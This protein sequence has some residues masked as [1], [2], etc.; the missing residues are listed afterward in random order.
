MTDRSLDK[1]LSRSA[2]AAAVRDFLGYADA[3][4]P[5]PSKP[6]EFLQHL[7]MDGVRGIYCSQLLKSGILSGDHRDV[8]KE[9]ILRELIWK[10][11]LGEL[12]LALSKI[13][14]SAIVLKG[15]S[16]I[17][18]LYQGA[19]LRPLSDIDL[20]VR[21]EDLPVVME[22]LLERGFLRTS[23][24]FWNFTR[25]GWNVD[26]HDSPLNQYESAFPLPVGQFWADSLPLHPGAMTLR[27]LSI[28]HALCVAILHTAKHSFRRSI[29]LVDIVLLLQLAN[30]K[31]L[32]VQLRQ[33]G[34]ERYLSY[35]IYLLRLRFGEDIIKADTKILP[36]FTVERVYL[37]ACSEGHAPEFLGMLL[38]IFTI[39]SNFAKIKYLRHTLFPEGFT[40]A[41][42]SRLRNLWTESYRLLISLPKLRLRAN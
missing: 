30:E 11:L 27:K 5:M 15:A 26:L 12:D 28:E 38:P 41:R 13:N 34:A 23:E 19:G 31:T 9:D 22:L 33:C 21:P 6:D 16:A 7:F 29:W 42:I 14:V 39:S 18:G 25:A 1:A 40:L 2:S 36:L 17:Y 10:Q 32:D 8:L 24:R 20:L 37:D 3:A 4:L 35:A